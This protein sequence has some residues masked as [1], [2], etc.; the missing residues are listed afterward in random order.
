[1]TTM[2]AAVHRDIFTVIPGGWKRKVDILG[3]VNLASNRVFVFSSYE[4]F[5]KNEI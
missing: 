4:Y 5:S 1:M 2:S 3:V